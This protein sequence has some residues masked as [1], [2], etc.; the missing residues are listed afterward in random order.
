MDNVATVGKKNNAVQ[1]FY[2]PPPYLWSNKG[3]NVGPRTPDNEDWFVG[4]FEQYLK[5]KGNLISVGQWS[6]KMDGL[7]DSI[8]MVQTLEDHCVKFIG[9]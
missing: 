8:T 5:G 2:W 1:C 3:Y 6:E 4:R 9:V 7:R